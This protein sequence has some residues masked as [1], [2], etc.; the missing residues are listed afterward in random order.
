MA[1]IPSWLSNYSS[2]RPARLRAPSPPSPSSPSRHS[3]STSQMRLSTPRTGAR[4]PWR[5]RRMSC[6]GTLA[7]HRRDGCGRTCTR[8]SHS[9]MPTPPRQRLGRPRRHPLG[10]DRRRRRPRRLAHA[11]RRPSSTP[12]PSAASPSTKWTAR[13]TS[14]AQPESTSSLWTLRRSDLPAAPA[15]SSRRVRAATVSRRRRARWWASSALGRAAAVSRPTRPCSTPR[16][17]TS[18]MVSSRARRSS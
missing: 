3:T 17:R 4:A 5:W 16:I 9:A 6:T 7:L 10:R 1:S 12:R 18:A 8:R 11:Q 14:P 2:R 15:A 13:S